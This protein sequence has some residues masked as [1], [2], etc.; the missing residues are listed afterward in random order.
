MIRLLFGTLLLAAC[1]TTLTFESQVPGV[2]VH[3]M[4][5][6]T[7]NR[8]YLS[9]ETLLPGQKSTE[10]FIL[11][12]DEDKSGRVT[13]ELEKDGRRIALEV[14]NAFKVRGGEDNTFVLSPDT[15]VRH[16]LLEE[17]PMALWAE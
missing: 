14:E 11:V 4:R 2:T 15:R 1:D 5:L 3:D 9:P 6:T 12:D 10:V 8:T 16:P 13:F 7:S 17:A